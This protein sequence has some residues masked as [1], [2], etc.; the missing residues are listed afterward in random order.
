[1][2]YLTTHKEHLRKDT[3][4][5]DAKFVSI[6]SNDFLDGAAMKIP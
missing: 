1:M 2:N 3:K 4:V 5:L 6:I